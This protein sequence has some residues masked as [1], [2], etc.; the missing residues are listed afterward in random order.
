LAKA[1]VKALEYRSSVKEDMLKAGPVNS[2]EDPDTSS[3]FPRASTP[4]PSRPLQANT[5]I[6]AP[7]ANILAT[8][9]NSVHIPKVLLVDDNEINL[10][11]LVTFMR[12]LGYNYDTATD[13]L[14]ALEKYKAAA[15]E[16]KFEF[17]LMD[18]SMPVMDGLVSTREIRAFERKNSLLDSPSI[19][20][21]LTGLA[22]AK[23]QQEAFASGVNLFLTKPIM[24]KTLMS[25]LGRTDASATDGVG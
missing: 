10:K 12:K 18:I 11:I 1:L 20:I 8:P 21:A 17:V 3:P 19:I 15:A 2:Q 24:L 6:S 16:G 14:Q 5:S 25:L 4:L 13:G 23:A 9:S 7:S 22:S